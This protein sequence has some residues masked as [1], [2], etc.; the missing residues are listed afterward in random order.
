MDY[1]RDAIHRGRDA[2]HHAFS[3]ESGHPV[4][5]DEWRRERSGE[6]EALRRT[7]PGESDYSRH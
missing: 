3:D 2:A 1:A 6:D 7:R 5:E 4:H